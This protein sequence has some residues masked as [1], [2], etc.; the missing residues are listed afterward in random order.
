[1]PRPGTR[2]FQRFPAVSVEPRSLQ[3]FA[4]ATASVAVALAVRWVLGLFDPST[5]PFAAFLVAIVVTSILAGSA[6][7]VF[8]AAAG[9]LTSVLMIAPQVP[10]AFGWGGIF[11]FIAT[12]G[13]II[14]I[15]DE[16]RRLL[17][18]VQQKEI[19]LARQQELMEAENSVLAMIAEDRPLVETMRGIAETIER[20]LD[21]QVLASVLLLDAKE[22]KLRHCAAPRLPKAYNEAID[23]LDIGPAVGSCGTA[24]YRG[25]P[26]YVSDI[27]T[28]PLWKDFRSLADEHGLRACWSTPFKTPSGTVLGTF[29]VY[30]R[31]PHAPQSSEIEIVNLLTKIA[32]LAVERN[33]T[34]EQRE[35][36]LREL[37]HRV[38]NSM[39]V[40]RSVA[41]TSLRPHVDREHY[42]DF[43][44]RLTALGEVQS[45]LTKASWAGVDLKTLLDQ[46]AI[47]PF[48]GTSDRFRVKGPPVTLPAAIT[49]P[50]AMAIHELC[51]NAL[52]YGALK[53]S[54]GIVTVEWG[55]RGTGSQ[56]NFCLTWTERGGPTVRPPQTTGFGSLM[57][58]KA[59]AHALGGTAQWKYQPEGLICEILLPKSAFAEVDPEV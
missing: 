6:A 13:L 35:L 40:V 21:H 57:I 25:E 16:Y 38:K 26:V 27:Q 14:W 3:A 24:A 2:A 55:F 41:S 11:Q 33:N 29:A 58:E 51:T 34:N 44:K 20:Y 39:A 18:N 1:M 19:T 5:P 46:L 30:H 10:S 12:S 32:V 45:L 47:Q 56:A 48:T 50:F 31:Q 59:L 37:V 52:K 23:G 17:R 53:S 36:L 22:K 9:L 42:R 43:E 15:A 49:L 7:G 54:D 8:A 28:D 4:L